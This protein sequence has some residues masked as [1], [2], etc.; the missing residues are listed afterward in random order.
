MSRRVSFG[1]EDLTK[2]HHDNWHTTSDEY[3]V[4][5]NKIERMPSIIDAPH[6]PNLHMLFNN[7]ATQTTQVTE[8][9]VQIEH[10]KN[11]NQKVHDED[12][13]MEAE[14]FILQKRK[15]FGLCKWMTMKA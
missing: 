12:V 6:Y 2:N 11:S 8:S 1:H 3:R 5:V 13:N 15:A 10:A 9:T 14:K 4:H 7:K